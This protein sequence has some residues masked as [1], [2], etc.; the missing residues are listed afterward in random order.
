MNDIWQ[1]VQ[2][3]FSL[4]FT[5]DGEVM[6]I[7]A[8][9]LAVSVSALV[10]SA[11]VGIPL[12]IWLAF[13]RF[14]S[15]R[16]AIAFLYTGMGFP[17]V[18]V[19]L[20]VFLLLSR[21]G[22]L[23][24]SGWLY[25]PKAMVLAQVIIAAPIIAGFTMVAV[26][27]VNRNLRSQARSLGANNLQVTMTMLQEAR[28]GMLVAVLAGFGR[29]LSEVGAVMIVGGNLKGSTQVLTTATVQFTRMGL[30]ER[31]IAMGMILLT[32]TFLT[33]LLWVLLQGGALQ[34]S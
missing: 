27:A 31:S 12:G 16:L 20:V 14:A 30:F 11:A 21:S 1:G 28:V 22:P 34:E 25:T 9:S 2:E 26:M 23:G 7:V 6:R 13:R 32:L 8:L 3:A 5:A 33:S 15:R 18:V 19:G 29:I 4:I 17:P 10:L 24:W